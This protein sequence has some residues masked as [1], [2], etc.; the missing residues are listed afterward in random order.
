MNT[1]GVVCVVLDG[2]Y[3][4]SSHIGLD[5]NPH[6][7]GQDILQFLANGFDR[8]PFITRLNDCR[9]LSKPELQHQNDRQG[10]LGISI[11]EI[12]Q[13]STDQVLM[14]DARL[15]MNTCAWVYVIDLDSQV[16]VILGQY[17]DNASQQVAD[18]TVY[19]L[20]DLP[21]AEAFL[22]DFTD[23]EAE[24]AELLFNTANALETIRGLDMN[25]NVGVQIAAFIEK[26]MDDFLKFAKAR[27][28]D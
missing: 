27:K 6:G 19:P 26:Q 1:H 23:P 12:I 18:S 14:E 25:D 21:S 4:V 11:L 10:P 16:F 22:A 13:H 15:A 7:R 8:E 3:K 17:G 28:T 20:N 9:F 5:A 2:D 24:A